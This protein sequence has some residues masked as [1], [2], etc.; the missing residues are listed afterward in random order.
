MIE[1]EIILRILILSRSK[2]YEKNI[3]PNLV[4]NKYEREIFRSHHHIIIRDNSFFRTRRRH[5]V[6][7]NVLKSLKGFYLRATALCLEK[8]LY[9]VVFV[10]EILTG[11]I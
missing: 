5:E 11:E 7:K 9:F 8:S 6:G 10:V 2:I 1:I 3:R 4:K